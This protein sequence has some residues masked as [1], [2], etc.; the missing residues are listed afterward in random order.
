MD[1]AV[2]DT[3]IDSKHPDL[4][5]VGGVN[6]AGGNPKSFNDGNGHGTHVSGTIAALDNAQGVVGVAPGARLW[7]VRVL[8]N[9]GSGFLSDVIAG[10]D[11]VTANA[12]TIEVAN[13]SLGWTGSDTNPNDP[14]H[15][16]IIKHVF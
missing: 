8:N 11:W 7:G 9:Q 14:A 13:M 10:I 1:V 15:E 4:N 2:I 3:G 5:V 16:A 6:F 12:S